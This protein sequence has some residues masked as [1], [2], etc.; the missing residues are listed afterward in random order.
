MGFKAP[1]LAKG[2]AILTAACSA[3]HPVLCSDLTC[4]GSSD[5]AMSTVMHL[6]GDKKRTRIYW[7]PHY[8]AGMAGNSCSI[9]LSPVMMGTLRHGRLW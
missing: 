2:L 9:T 8:R 5:I 1:D 7:S 4:F 6:G 3:S